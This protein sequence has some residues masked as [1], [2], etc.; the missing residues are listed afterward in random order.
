MR[1]LVVCCDGTWASRK[2]KT[3]GV[4]RPTNVARLYNAL[5][6]TGPDGQ[7]QLCFYRSGVGAQGG[8]GE[9]VR[10][11]AFGMG[12]KRDLISAYR[13]LAVRR[14]EHP[15][16]EFISLFGFSRGAYT[17]RN[18]AR[19][20]TEDTFGL[21]D[22]GNTPGL[23]PEQAFEAA[24]EIY[25][26]YHKGDSPPPRY[27]FFPD[28]KVHFLGVWDT[29]GAVGIPESLDLM[30][31]FPRR[32][33]F[34]FRDTQLSERV[35]YARHAVA[36]D[37]MR[38]P[39][40]PTLWDLPVNTTTS[41][42]Q[43]WFP[44]DH[45]DVGG[46]HPETGLSDG[47]L[48]WMIRE[49]EKA[50]LAFDESVRSQIRPDATGILHEEG[51][52]FRY[53]LL[54]SQPRRVDLIDQTNP[55]ALND[56]VFT[57]F[58]ESV[59][60][61]QEHPLITVGP[62]RPS[63]VI[64]AGQSEKATIDANEPWNYTGFWLD[65]G[66]YD[67]SAEGQWADGTIPAGPDGRAT[68][69]DDM[70]RRHHRVAWFIRNLRLPFEWA[71]SACQKKNQAA[72]LFATRRVLRDHTTSDRK[73]VPWMSMVGVIANGDMD[74]DTGTQVHQTF[75]IGKRRNDVHVDKPGYLYVFANDAWGF[76]DN[77]QGTVELTVVRRS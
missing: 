35:E 4:P 13:W 48:D 55:S 3:R 64:P 62:Y 14:H 44:G 56:S 67:F 39:F 74:R 54:S 73:W 12:L 46:G 2:Q 15:E 7:Q 77:N 24:E 19:L 41:F 9:R 75:Q 76:Y 29:V 20:L 36:L 10:G 17:V 8:L 1:H 37:E 72:Q 45:S 61:R 33:S 52:S 22:I 25:A 60:I 51:A 26:C 50:G 40:A 59:F 47:A 21:L 30:L 31:L 32:R 53:R 49:A 23:R 70:D 58:H 43:V 65:S 66:R 5:A 18:L 6:L 16:A 38:G 11:G 27:Q 63:K 34:A 71:L 42:E 57:G 69:S 68:T 28:R